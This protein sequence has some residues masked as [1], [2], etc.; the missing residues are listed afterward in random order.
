MKYFLLLLI[1]LPS[2]VIAQESKGIHFEHEDSWATIKA[3]AKAEN[4]YIFMDCYTTWCGPCIYMSN[5][6]FKTPTAGEF[7]NKQFINVKVQLDT[8]KNDNAEIKKWYKDAANIATKYAIKAYPTFLFFDPNGNVVHKIVGGGEAEEFVKKSAAALDPQSQYFTLLKNYEDG[9][10]TPVIL[11]NLA[12]ASYNA[13]ELTLAN[14]AA[15][16]YI[17]TQTDL[18]TK[19]NVE[20]LTMFTQSSEDRGFKLM[21]ENMETVD[22]F[23]GKGVAKKTVKNIV[24]NEEILSKVFALYNSGVPPQDLPEPDW[25]ALE[26]STNNKYPALSDEIMSYGKVVFYITK[27]DWERFA[28]A[29]LSFMEKYGNDVKPDE[30]NQFAWAVFQNCDDQACLENALT[31]SKKS[32]ENQENAMFIDTYA[33]LLHKLGRTE[34]AILWEEKALNLSSDKEKESYQQMIDK[35]KA[36]EKT[37]N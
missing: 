12:K 10:R 1:A 22:K 14:E 16:A 5:V 23:F 8:T 9:E 3:K 25:N 19:E 34:E 6:V 2:L 18:L 30:L 35:M 24:L 33:N 17:A 4:K 20:F 31:W 28:P 26:N 21:M 36:G 13:Y 11:K 27:Q 15:D 32:F 29:V 7:F 37:W